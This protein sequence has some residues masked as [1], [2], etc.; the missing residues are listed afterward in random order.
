MVHDYLKSTEDLEGI[1]DIMVTPKLGVASIL[2]FNFIIQDP[3]HSERAGRPAA[4][5]G[6]RSTRSEYCDLCK[7]KLNRKMDATPSFGVTMIS[8]VP[9]NPQLTLIKAAGKF[10]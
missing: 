7:I 8:E 2:R 6:L 1:S 3:Q 10:G 5:K 4:I 9:S